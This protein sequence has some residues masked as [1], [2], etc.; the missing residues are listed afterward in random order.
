M[1]YFIYGV[2]T[3]KSIIENEN[4]IKICKAHNIS[5]LK[6]YPNIAKLVFQLQCDNCDE[7]YNNLIKYLATKYIQITNNDKRYFKGDIATIEIDTIMFVKRNEITNYLMYEQKTVLDEIFNLFPNYTQD[8]LFGGNHILVRI[9]MDI[10]NIIIRYITPGE[11][12][13]NISKT[14]LRK[15][16]YCKCDF[17]FFTEIIKNKVI[18]NGCVYFLQDLL[19]NLKPY[20]K[21]I[22]Y[23]NN[24]DIINSLFKTIL[25]NDTFNRTLTSTIFSNCIMT[26]NNNTKIH[27]KYINNILII[28]KIYANY[29]LFD[30]EQKELEKYHIGV[31]FH[32]V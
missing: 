10:D 11:I 9:D 12:K 24:I 16:L 2:I 19:D 22:T 27:C 32:I 29:L 26:Y 6:K 14:I 13:Y 15:D 25:I 28:D 30:N 4:V 31:E 8:T 20:Y 7:I 21:Y 23:T 3:K 18:M 17:D 1:N 5:Q